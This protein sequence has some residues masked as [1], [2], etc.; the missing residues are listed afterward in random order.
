M[1]EQAANGA[2]LPLMAVAN[3]LVKVE[4]RNNYVRDREGAF[5]FIAH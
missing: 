5:M 4:V 2:M 3:W 1:Q